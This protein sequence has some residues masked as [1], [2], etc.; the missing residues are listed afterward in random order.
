MAMQAT[1][2]VD[3]QVIINKSDEMKS[4]RNSISGIM[5]QI[6]DKMRSLTNIW[7]SE[8]SVTY[9]TKFSKIHKDV[10]DMLHTVDQYTY[11]L[12]EIAQNCITVEQRVAQASSALP[13]DVFGV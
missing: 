6:D 8:A 1:L 4:I 12:D 11:N 2:K 5:Q 10:E 13:S 3:A 9:Q 7:E